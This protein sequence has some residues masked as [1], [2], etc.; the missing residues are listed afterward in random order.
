VACGYDDKRP[1]ITGFLAK[2]TALPTEF[3]LIPKPSKIQRRVGLVI[4]VQQIK[5]YGVDRAGDGSD[6]PDAEE[7]FVLRE[8]ADRPLP[9]ASFSQIGAVS[10]ALPIS[11]TQ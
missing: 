6:L 9:V 3:G 10:R 4:T 8:A 1:S 7:I 5:S 2:A 11:D